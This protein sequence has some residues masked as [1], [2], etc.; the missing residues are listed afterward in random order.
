MTVVGVTSDVAQNDP[1]RPELNALVYA[2]YQQQ[3]RGSLWALVRAPVRLGNLAA[4]IQ[5]EVQAMDAALPIQLGPTRLPE[6][7]VD[8]YQ[9]RGVS[10][11][12]FLMCALIA[13]MLASIGLYAVLAHSVSQRSQEIGVRMA[14][15]GTVRDIVTLVVN[16]GMRPL[17]IG[18]GIGVATAGALMPAL[19][20]VLVQVS[21]LDPLTFVMALTALVLAALLGCWIPA[22]RAARVD[23]VAVLKT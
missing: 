14:M 8:R 23:P 17:G 2:P 21:P 10:G 4:P 22:R 3:A 1:L 19:K 11:A 13:L 9:Y 15:G 16:Q 6:R 18:L 7:F 12:L 20:S 5:R